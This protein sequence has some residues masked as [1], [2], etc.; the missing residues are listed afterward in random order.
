LTAFFRKAWLPLVIGAALS[1]FYFW[2]LARV[3]FHPD[4]STYLWMSADFQTLISDPLALAWRADQPDDLRQRYRLI[5][6]PMTRTLLGLS[7]WAFGAPPQKSDWD[8]SKTWAENQAAGAL[9]EPRARL[10]GRGVLAL[11][12]PLDLL[13]IYRLGL[14]LRGPAAGALA[15][16]LFGLNALILLHTRRAMAEAALVTGALL[17]V[18]SLVEMRSHAWLAGSTLALAVSAKQTAAVL[19]PIGLL[20]AALP[21]TAC[22]REPQS[23]ALALGWRWAQLLGAFAL[24]TL[25]LNPVSWNAPWRAAQAGW[26]ERQDLLARQT[27]DYASLQPESALDTPARKA[28]AL[29]AHLYLT[30]PAFAETANYQAETRLSEQAYLSIPGHNLLRG[31]LAGGA[32]F[33]LTLAGIS[34]A[35]LDLRRKE[36]QARLDILIVLAATLALGLALFLLVPL[37]WQRYVAPLV[38]LTCLWIAYALASFAALI[39]QSFRDN[40]K[41]AT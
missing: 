33:A 10:I 7:Q 14:R 39:A 24:V 6:A 11:L 23:R 5:D 34:L 2:G 17:A 28:A 12:F 15:M 20:A 3:P 32:M 37:P 38:P 8:W 18:W 16:I 26:Q 27:A 21:S 35:L 9:P 31:L 30:P 25:V 29:L 4:E 19:L 1:A 22:E 13:L 36:L 41:T 40:K